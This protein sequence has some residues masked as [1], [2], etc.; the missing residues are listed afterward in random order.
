MKRDIRKVNDKL[1]CNEDGIEIAGSIKGIETISIEDEGKFGNGETIL[2]SEINN[3]MYEDTID[4]KSKT[5]HLITKDGITY[6]GEVNEEGFKPNESWWE[7][8][9]TKRVPVKDK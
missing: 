2:Q 1:S 3:K 8:A 7:I 9:L 4:L 5:K 6:L